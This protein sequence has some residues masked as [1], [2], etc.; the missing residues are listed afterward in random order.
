MRTVSPLAR[1]SPG[2]PLARKDFVRPE[3]ALTV[4]APGR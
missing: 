4:I 2:E 3:H 1:L